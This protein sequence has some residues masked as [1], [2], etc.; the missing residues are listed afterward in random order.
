MRKK[1]ERGGRKWERVRE[2]ESQSGKRLLL[3]FVPKIVKLEFRGEALKALIRVDEKLISLLPSLLLLTFDDFAPK[4]DKN[5]P[6]WSSKASLFDLFMG[7]KIGRKV[8]EWNVAT[9]VCLVAAAAENFSPCQKFLTSL[10]FWAEDVFVAKV[11]VLDSQNVF[12]LI[13]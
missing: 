3:R 12:F 5:L 8:S 13:L 2:Q 7:N 10:I 4:T 11:V 6:L 9:F 1:R